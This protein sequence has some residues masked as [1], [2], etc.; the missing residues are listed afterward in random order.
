ME[1]VVSILQVVRDGAFRHDEALKAE[2]ASVVAPSILDDVARLERE[3]IRCDTLYLSREEGGDLLSFFMAAF[4]TLEIEGRP[5]PALYTGLCATRSGMK[6]TGEGGKIFHHFVLDAQ[7]WERQ[8]QK[9]LTVWGTTAS[10][11]VFLRPGSCS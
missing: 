3:F 2:V 10:P 9:K 7:Q 1:E 5:V 11:V 6:S 8:H 4:E